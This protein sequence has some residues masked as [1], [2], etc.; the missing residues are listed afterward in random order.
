MTARESWYQR[1]P[2]Y[3]IDLAPSDRPVQARW[4]DV[5]VAASARALVVAE[6]DHAP[7]VYFPLEDVALDYFVATDHHTF[8]PFKGEA[9]YWTLSVAGAVAENVMWAYLDPFPEVAGLGGYAAFYSDRVAV[10]E[11]EPGT[12]EP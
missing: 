5:M 4:G 3:R 8:C 10:S 12:G 11:G 2:D 6:T 7:V 9:S 1:C